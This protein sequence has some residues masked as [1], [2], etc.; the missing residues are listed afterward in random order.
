[1][2]RFLMLLAVA[3][4]AGGMYVAAATGS[5]QAK[6]PTAKQF[7]ALKAQVAVLQKKV[8]AA[9]TLAND[10]AVVTVHCLMHQL[11]GVAE[12][13]SSTSGYIFG[14]DGSSGT[15]TTALDLAPN[16]SAT[17]LV[18][19]FNSDPA[20]TQLIGAAGL[21]HVSGFAH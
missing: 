9:Q 2:K 13:G 18:A 8:K 5:Q 16:L 15:P 3:A 6:G 12:R 7:K 4:V 11:F 21:G 19:G 20:C 14:T 10:D 1:M 17:Y